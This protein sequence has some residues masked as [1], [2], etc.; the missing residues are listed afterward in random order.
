MKSVFFILLL[1]AGLGSKAQS[2]WSL[3]QC[4]DYA[5]S[6]NLQIKQSVLQTELSEQNLQSARGAYYPTLNA[7]GTNIYNFGQ[8]IDP[9]TNQFASSAVRANQFGLRANMNLFNGMRNANTAKSAQI[10]LEASRYELDAARN[11]VSLAVANA[12]LSV[13][14]AEELLFNANNQLQMT[15]K[16]VNRTQSLF[17]AG[18]IPKA[19]LLNLQ[20]QLAGEEL[21][22][23]NAENQ[24][25][26]SYLS[27]KQLIQLDS[28]NDFRIVKPDLNI[29]ENGDIGAT[30]GQV[31]DQAL[32]VMPQ[33][34]GAER[35]VLA[36]GKDLS[37]AKALY[38]PVLSLSGNIGTGY[39]GLRSD[40]TN[41]VISGQRLIGTTES[42][43]GVFQPNVTFPDLMSF[44]DQVNENFNQ[45]L[46]FTLSI[47][48][49]NGFQ[50]N[51][52][53]GRA[54]INREISENNLDIAKN[55]INQDIQRA[56]ADARAALKQFRA[57]EKALESLKESFE[58]A[59]QRFTVGMLNS[60]DYNNAK[61]NLT[62]AESDVLRAKYDFIFKSKILDFYQGKS[63]SLN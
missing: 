4:I 22:V 37:A 52:A 40:F 21:N 13:L 41:P 10:A 55:Q 59:E 46:G 20:A 44:G 9:F 42:G 60:V 3:E 26:L 19:D 49:F 24:V 38:Y 39:S 15:K 2:Y 61:L 33:I 17:E 50:N 62:R 54:K 30:P 63:I 58:Y 1:L 57:S 35:R 18:S 14:F 7:F 34:K 8:T 5:L 47:P 29:A 6:H 28:I 16:Q 43:E 51:T 12:Y 53:V 32:R 56:Y 31:Y 11:D 36:A 45:S 27:L 25:D 48:I 23:V